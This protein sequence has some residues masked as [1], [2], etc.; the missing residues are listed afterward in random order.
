MTRIETIAIIYQHP[1]VLLGMK[2]KKFGEG[3]YNG[4]GGGIEKGES[5]EDAIKREAMEEARIEII[6]PKREGK[7]LFKFDSDEQDHLIYFFKIEKFIGIPK[8][9][10]EMA[11]KWF[12]VNDI[13]YEKMW[14]DSQYWFP[15]LLNEERFKGIFYYD[16]HFRVRKYILKIDK[17]IKWPT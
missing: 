14:D 9:S 1:R 12:N 2:K 16:R 15:R 7:I 17:K 11:P 3:K 10:D 8:E 13:P 4:F 5:P 6:N